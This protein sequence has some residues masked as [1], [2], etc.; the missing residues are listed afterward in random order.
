MKYPES[1]K[2]SFSSKK[3]SIVQIAGARKTMRITFIPTALQSIAAVPKV[4]IPAPTRPPSSVCEVELGTL[5]AAET[6]DQSSA[7]IIVESKN[8]KPVRTLSLPASAALSIRLATV[9]AT[10]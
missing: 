6:P 2:T 4:T 7:E 1:A 9:T 3:P 5:N 10:L 8:K